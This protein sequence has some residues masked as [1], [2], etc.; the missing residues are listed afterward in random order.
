[1]TVE[2]VIMNKDAVALSADSAVTVTPCGRL[3]DWE[4]PKKTY[5]SVNK[6]F[7]LCYERPVGI[8][9]YGN[10]K[11][12]GVS[13]DAL[14]KLY[15]AKHSTVSYGRLEGYSEAFIRFL[16]KEA[17]DML[18]WPSLEERVEQ[19]LTFVSNLVFDVT[20]QSVNAPDE[21][22]QRNLGGKILKKLEDS[23]KQM[24][25]ESS[26]FDPDSGVEEI[27]PWLRSQATEKMKKAKEIIEENFQV[28]LP[29]AI[30]DQMLSVCEEKLSRKFKNERSSVIIAGYGEA[31]VFPSLTHHRIWGYHKSALH[32]EEVH[33]H[34]IS[35]TNPSVIFPRAQSATIE[36]FIRGFSIEIFDD[37][38]ST[39]TRAADETFGNFLRQEGFHDEKIEELLR[40]HK[41]K[42]KNNVFEA[43]FRFGYRNRKQV[44]RTIASMPKGELATLAE[45]L[46]DLTSLKLRATGKLETVGGPTD[47]ALISKGDGFVWMK[48]KAQIPM[49]LNPHLTSNTQT[50][51]T[52]STNPFG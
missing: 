9:V 2:V 36:A 1:M 8:M 32:F 41:K 17:P 18:D 47:V 13:W 16:D 7:M 31:E 30:T 6:V 23:L 5:P 37:E 4:S 24:Q 42:L 12:G 21:G 26:L 22:V 38:R 33:K 11:L 15:R 49:E 19:A 44:Y 14:I 43:M 3:P 29:E 45:A 50:L 40:A 25:N 10:A 28:Q 46:V 20:Q 34:K 35:L 51:K 48:N 27:K 52:V 39:F